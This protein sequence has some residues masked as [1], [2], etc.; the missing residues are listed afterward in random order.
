[1][2]RGLEALAIAFIFSVTVSLAA[3][4]VATIRP[5]TEYALVSAGRASAYYLLLS[6]SPE[7]FQ[8]RILTLPEA[9]PEYGEYSVVV[10]VPDPQSR[11]L[12]PVVV[13]F[14]P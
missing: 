2:H 10:L 14:E 12:V 7:D 13:S 9:R 11:D 6:R 8:A 5:Q 3:R 1:M 4:Y